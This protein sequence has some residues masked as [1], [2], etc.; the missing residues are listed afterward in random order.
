[1]YA[2]VRTYAGAGAKE[3]FDLL[4]A[5]QSEVEAVIRTVPGFVSFS[6][7]RTANGGFSVT[8]TQDRTGADESVR[9]ARDWIVANASELKASPPTVFEGPTFLDV[10]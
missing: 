10:T 3:L 9:K 7:A 2:V 6:L 4:D 1:M 8:V 5:R